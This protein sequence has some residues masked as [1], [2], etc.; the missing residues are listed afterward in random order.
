MKIRASNTQ[1][2]L[3]LQCGKKYY[4]RYKKKLRARDKGSA[5]Y[6]GSAFDAASD[7]LFHE[8]NLDKAKED[9]SNRW[10]AQEG[11]LNC[12]FSK[13]DLDTRLFQPSDISKLEAA[14][15]NLN[16][17]KPKQGFDKDGDVI[18]LVKEIKK[19]KENSYVRDLTK[20]EEHFLH[21]AH[22]LGM[23]R[24]GYLML[25]S[26]HKNILPHVSSVVSTQAKIDIDNGAGDSIVG[27][28]DLL[29][30]M[31][32]YKL[33]NGRVLTKD[34][35]V[36]AD[37]KTAGV[38]FWNKLDEIDRSDQLDVYLVS[39]QVQ[40]FSP[41]NL[42]CYMAVSKQVSKNETYNCA[43]CGHPKTG[44]HKTCDN[45]ID[46]DRCN[47]DWKGDVEYYCD[48]KIVIAERDVQEAQQ[49]LNDYND[50]VH[51]IKQEVFPRNREACNAYGSICEYAS[52]CGKYY[53]SPEEEEKALEKWRRE[54]GER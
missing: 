25:E 45:V 32:G 12:K 29:C 46:G 31:E 54:K 7:V 52:V 20:E 16:D 15:A 1:R 49:V 27:Y 3:Y 37:V 10:M 22:I 36:V 51:G 33:P 42:V 17:S 14:A 2:S 18:N 21:Y 19:L 47:G 53:P 30:Y 9:F 24:K 5:L 41:T 6:F 8:R 43:K 11:N 50:V 4:Y 28:I 34:D 40:E 13:T 23:L 38:T 39:P 48:S 26:F 44:R 35:L